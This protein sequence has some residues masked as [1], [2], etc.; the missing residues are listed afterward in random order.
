MPSNKNLQR[1][2]LLKSTAQLRAQNNAFKVKAEAERKASQGHEINQESKTNRHAS[3]K[4]IS[5]K[6]VFVW[7]LF[8]TA[9]SVWGGSTFVAETCRNVAISCTKSKD[10]NLANVAVSAAIMLNSNPADQELK[11]AIENLEALAAKFGDP[12]AKSSEK[13]RGFFSPLWMQ[14]GRNTLPLKTPD[15]PEIPEVS[16]TTRLSY[17]S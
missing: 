9:A 4:S 15:A 1:Y 5:R 6:K 11:K 7:G 12:S 17:G 8:A 13:S 3:G 10:F 2:E 14:R 16:Q